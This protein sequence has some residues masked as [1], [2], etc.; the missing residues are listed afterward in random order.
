MNWIK[1]NWLK[2]YHL[3]TNRN[4]ILFGL[5]L[6]SFLGVAVAMNLFYVFFIA[7]LIIQL[8]GFV[9]KPI[10]RFEFA[11]LTLL[12]WPF[13]YILSFLVI[14]IL[15]YIIVTPIGLFR[16]KKYKSGWVNSVVNIDK[17]KLNE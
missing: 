9:Y 2:Y 8:I 15:Y 5:L 11:T 17:K 1:I 7:L 16:N 3:H 4:M 13:G 12:T 10:L 6:S 14:G